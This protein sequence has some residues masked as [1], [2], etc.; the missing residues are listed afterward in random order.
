LNGGEISYSLR[1]L[2]G[3]FTSE[4]SALGQIGDHQFIILRALQSRKIS[5]KTHSLVYAIKED[6]WWLERHGYGI[7][8][9]WIPSHVGVM[10]NERSDRLA[11][12][13]VQCD[14]EFAPPVRPSDF[15]PL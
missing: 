2:S 14:T 8:I 15:R 11:G 4:L 10:G 3:V 5:P 6:S 12:E 13:A 1:E 9:I 7:H